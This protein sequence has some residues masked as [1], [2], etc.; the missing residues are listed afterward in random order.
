MCKKKNQPLSSHQR[1]EFMSPAPP[2]CSSMNYTTRLGY[3]VSPQR[4]EVHSHF[5]RTSW[6]SLGHGSSTHTA[7]VHN[8]TG[9][10]FIF[11]PHCKCSQRREERK[12]RE[13]RVQ[14]EKQRDVSS[15]L[16]HLTW[17]N[18][19]RLCGHGQLVALALSEWRVNK[20]MF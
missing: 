14:G 4:P 7:P 5:S 18:Q 16:L 19:T 8:H 1:E 17:R 12:P 3:E 9:S 6:T 10:G 13:M 15:C 20:M 11:D 2:M